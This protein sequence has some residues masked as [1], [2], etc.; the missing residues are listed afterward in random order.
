MRIKESVVL[1]SAHGRQL[2]DAQC[3]IKDT[4]VSEYKGCH[5]EEHSDEAIHTVSA[6]G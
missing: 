6:A 3:L 1:R 5:C 4:V 2:K